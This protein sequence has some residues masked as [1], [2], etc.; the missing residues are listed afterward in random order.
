MK[1]QLDEY[2]KFR[3]S[4][5]VKYT[6]FFHSTFHTSTGEKGLS[7]DSIGSCAASKMRRW[8]STGQ[9]AVHVVG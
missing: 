1:T 5:P 2:Q 4:D 6:N 8:K 7:N 3:V 9:V